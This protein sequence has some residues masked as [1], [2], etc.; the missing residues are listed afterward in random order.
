MP[1]TTAGNPPEVVSS[2]PAPDL[3]ST[4][5]RRRF[6]AVGGA[7]VG[8]LGAGA[9]LAACGSGSGS[10][11][12][13]SGPSDTLT[14]GV[15]QEPDTLDP[16]ASGLI[17]SSL[18]AS[19]IF[20]PLV[21]WLPTQDGGKQLY[22]GLATSWQVAPDATSYTFKLR[23]DVDFHDGTHFT[24]A[25]VKATL[26]HIVDPAT[27]SRSAK[28]ALGPY[29][30]TRIV[31]DYTVEVRFSQP[32]AAFLHEMTTTVF[33]ISSPA[34]LKQYGPIGFGSHPVGTGPFKFQEYVTQDHVSLVQ[35]PGYKWG[36]S[37]FGPP[38]PAKLK[39][40]NF[41]ILLDATARY[42][43]LRTGQL[44]LAWN[45]NPSDIQS[46]RSTSGLTHY[47]VPSTGQPYGFPINV[48]KGPTDDIRVRQ[49][50]NFAVDQ[51]TLN[52]TVLQ[53]AYEAAHN[54]ITPSTPGYD[55]AADTMYA[56]DPVKAKS[57]LDQAGWV[58]AG[59]GTRAKGGQP[60][61]L[62]IL[63]QS[64]NG[65]DLPTQYVVSQLK[66]VG[67]SAKTSSQP[68]LTA[69]AS[70]NEG[71]QNLSAI[72]YY[73]VDPYLLNN[74]VTSEQIPSGFNWAHYSDPSV[75]SGIAQANTVVDDAARTARYQQI[76]RT[77]M[78]AA[79]FLPLWN[80]SGVF[81]AASNLTGLHFGVTGYPF[82]HAAALV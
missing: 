21:W 53:G 8:V 2:R 31:D 43:A 79:I 32:N 81:S 9:F 62:E 13:S 23:Q 80:V 38:G 11:V 30:E 25:A 29:Q 41:K 78:E 55:K 68:F 59:S 45:L 16:G 26:D 66:A 77:L 60:L 51:D 12:A 73:D 33:G 49:A 48:K 39:N 36:P 34:A 47:N 19:G 5:S 82:F 14:V 72:F 24:A 52:K 74:L 65:F 58:A 27:K 67:I 56:Y 44:Q 28:G 40:L 35:N 54:V 22:P 3:P 50:I 76:T 4:L 69:A 71:V 7:T 6:L 64:S 70:Y 63:I 18:I 57:L 61:E 42:N 75:D 17:L 37:A 15:Y 10:S 1:G 46:V 20:D